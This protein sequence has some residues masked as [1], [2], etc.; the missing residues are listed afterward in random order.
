MTML[1]THTT[2]AIARIHRAIA[3]SSS[4]FFFQI[5]VPTTRNRQGNDIGMSY[6]S[7]IF[8]TS[9]EQ[10]RIGGY[11][12]RCRGLRPLAGQ[13]GNRGDTSPEGHP[14]ARPGFHRLF[15]GLCFKLL[16]P[17]FDDNQLVLGRT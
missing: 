17:V 15:C 6:R 9:Q 1:P 14:T 4:K 11:D 16:E 7:A 8:Y 13:G 3:V 5:H 12:R 10:K 2:N